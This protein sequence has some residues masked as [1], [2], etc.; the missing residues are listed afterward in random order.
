MKRM[1]KT[2][3]KRVCLCIYCFIYLCMYLQK[4]THKKTETNENCYVKMKSGNKVEEK[5][6][7]SNFSDSSIYI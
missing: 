7:E 3:I 1:K 5:E 6:K 2:H 4:E